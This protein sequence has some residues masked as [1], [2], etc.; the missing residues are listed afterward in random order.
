[1]GNILALQLPNRFLVVLKVEEI[2][3][4]VQTT[5]LWGQPLLFSATYVPQNYYFV[6]LLSQWTNVPMT[7]G[8]L[9]QIPTNVN[10]FPADY[11]LIPQPP[12]VTPVAVKTA[13]LLAA[14]VDPYYG[15]YTTFAGNYNLYFGLFQGNWQQTVGM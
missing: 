7:W 13:T 15:A 5:T 6:Q 10:Q 2:E 1:M 14:G 8:E 4:Q 9:S 11:L 12:P 3:Q